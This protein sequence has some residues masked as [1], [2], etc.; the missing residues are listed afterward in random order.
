MAPEIQ[1]NYCAQLKVF[2]RLLMHGWMLSI[3]VYGFLQ[4]DVATQ[5]WPVALMLTF[6]LAI[7]Q[8]V[9][10]ISRGV[11]RVLG[12]DPCELLQWQ[13][14]QLTPDIEENTEK[15]TVAK[16]GKGQKSGFLSFFKTK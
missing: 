6:K 1:W 9:Y 15:P 16:F 13:I 14:M 3:S 2:L 4:H 7:L 5:M 10:D 11:H 8:Y 12:K